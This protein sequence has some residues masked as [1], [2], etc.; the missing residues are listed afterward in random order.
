[1]T[2]TTERHWTPLTDHERGIGAT[3]G[4]L[5]PLAWFMCLATITEADETEIMHERRLVEFW[6]L[7]D[8]AKVIMELRERIVALET[9]QQRSTAA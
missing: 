6:N 9:G 4:G 2:S 1:M 8:T 5:A 7:I 3:P